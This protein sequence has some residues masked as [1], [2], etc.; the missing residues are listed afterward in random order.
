MASRWVFLVTLTTCVVGIGVC[1][2]L[3]EPIIA[4]LLVV[5][6]VANGVAAW[7]TSRGQ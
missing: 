5:A 3:G 4:A 1:L 6:S 2:V 7:S